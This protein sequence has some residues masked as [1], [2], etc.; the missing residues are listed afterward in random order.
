MKKIIFILTIFLLAMHGCEKY[1]EAPINDIIIT[2]QVEAAARPAIISGTVECPVSITKIEL[3]IDSD[4]NFSNHTVHDIELSDKAFSILVNE[5]NFNT[6]YYYK[7]VVYN[8]VDMAELDT[9]SFTT[10]DS[11]L[12]SVRTAEVSSITTN[13]AVCGGNVTSD[14]YLSVT[15]RG[16]CWSTSPNPTITDNKTT[17]GSGTGSFTSNITGLTA[18]TTYYVR[19]YATNN[20]G[21]AYG[22]EKSFTTLLSINGYDWVDLGLPSGLKWAT[23]NVG[24]TTPEGYGNFY[25]WGETTTKRLY[26]QSNSVTYNQEISDFSGNVTYDAARA[27]WGSTWRMPTKAEMEELRDNCTWTWTSQ[28]GVNG[29]RVT[30]PNGN[31]IFLPATGYCL[32]LSRYGVGERGYYWSS[33]PFES[34]T[35][36]AY[37]LDF[38]SGYRNVY[39]DNRGYGRPVRPVS[40]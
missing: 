22:E 9:K 31:S 20:I 16:V 12:A 32:G 38:S 26:D 36:N 14:G 39:W 29:M 23:C 17:D 2:D 11:T 18:N 35:S 25:A 10:M 5:L 34:G 13:S 30:G 40:D 4:E 33:T 27:N 7:Y 37:N 24:A 15:A 28:N 19:A 1:P 3:W 21:T 6:T 8:A